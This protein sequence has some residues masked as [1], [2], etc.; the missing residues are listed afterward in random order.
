MQSGD[1]SSDKLGN[2]K[3]EELS[4]VIASGGIDGAAKASLPES[5]NEQRSNGVIVADLP[6]GRKE[7]F[8]QSP[9][10]LN[11]DFS[12]ICRWGS[13]QDK[14]GDRFF[15]HFHHCYINRADIFLYKNY[16]CLVGVN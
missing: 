10:A 5:T 9:D 4:N 12:T 7:Q 2:Q 13:S 16:K 3:E 6:D 15:A 1:E 11:C 8:I 14:E